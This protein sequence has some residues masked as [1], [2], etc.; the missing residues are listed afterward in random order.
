M[1]ADMTGPQI[2]TLLEQAVGDGGKGIQVSGLT[3]TYDPSEPAGSRVVSI[4]LTDGT[5]INL[6]DTSKAYKVATNDYL[7]T[8]D[9]GFT[10]F[11]DVTFI[12]TNIPVRDALVENVQ[13][14]GRITARLEGRVENIQN[15]NPYEPVTRA[16]FAGILVRILEL[17]EDETAA[18]FS[19]VPAGQK[20][21]ERSVRQ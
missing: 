20:Y 6:T 11:K 13:N 21:A 16:E 10:V 3:F 4:Y 17:T 14:A 18:R 9:D 2:K 1:T 12:N 15:A 7:A 19:D 5:P 8:G